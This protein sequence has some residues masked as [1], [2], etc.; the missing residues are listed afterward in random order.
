LISRQ[1]KVSAKFV[2][3]KFP[4]LIPLEFS[5][6]FSAA[7]KINQ[8]KRGGIEF[9]LGSLSLS[10]SLSS[11]DIIIQATFTLTLVSATQS[12]SSKWKIEN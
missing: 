9:Y 12:R 8:W 1:I 3:T 2:G 6:F 7:Q 11:T 10:L 4:I 5:L